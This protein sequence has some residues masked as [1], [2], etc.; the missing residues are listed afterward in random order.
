M[1]YNLHTTLAEAYEDVNKLRELMFM[2][3]YEQELFFKKPI[4]NFNVGK[5]EDLTFGQVNDLAK[6]I[7]DTTGLNDIVDILKYLNIKL[8]NAIFH[9]VTQQYYYIV[10]EI[11]KI[12]KNEQLAL[13]HEPSALEEL[14]GLERF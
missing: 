10:S 3:N 5:L 4:D 2:L 13:S 6:M 12:K 7:N 8:N 9:K 1:Q 14:A 11:Q